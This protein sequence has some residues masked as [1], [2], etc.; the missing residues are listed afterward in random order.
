[1]KKLSAL[2]IVSV[3]FL[4]LSPSHV[5]AKNYS[6]C[7]VEI[8]G[9]MTK[10]KEGP[11]PLFNFYQEVIKRI[12][13]KTGHT[14]ELQ[15]AP[16]LRCQNLFFKREID[17]IW[18]YIISGEADRF[19][20]AGYTFLPIYSMPIIMGGYYIF[21]R[22][23]D[24]VVHKVA[25]LEGKSVVS[26]RGYGIPIELE[27]STKIT[28]SITNGNELIPPMLL[29]KRVDAGIIQTGWVP[30]LREQGL[31]EGLHHGEVID[32]WGG[33]FTFYPDEEGV[34]LMNSFS[35]TILELVTEGKY[36]DM[37]TGAP[38]YIPNY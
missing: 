25:D 26:A 8:P 7:T 34:E 32:F 14:F 3:L 35:N 36:R 21:T 6:V 10:D 4:T 1:M 11:Q 13:D 30:T 28:K 2:Y 31:L 19:K 5:H 22:E 12:S 23:E 37:M 20:E 27:K 33:S 18:P 17:I 9:G 16:S 15:F 29:G 38:Y 24:P